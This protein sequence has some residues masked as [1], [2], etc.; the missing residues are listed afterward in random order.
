MKKLVLVFWL[1]LAAAVGYPQKIDSELLEKANAGNVDAQLE[2]GTIY[3]KNGKFK[4][5][6]NW[7][8]KAAE[9]GNFFAMTFLGQ[10]YATG[11]G[12]QQDSSMAADL[13]LKVAI[14]D[15]TVKAR[16][17]ARLGL[18]AL[19][20]SG[21]YGRKPDGTP[22]VVNGCTWIFI[23][24]QGPEI[25]AEF[26]GADRDLIGDVLMNLYKLSDKYPN[27]LSKE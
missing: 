25:F 9:K 1:V 16:Y 13:L 27:V 5:A 14:Q 6:A 15:G 7:F 8:S 24:G 17:P 19:Y 21:N 12:V 18:G 3:K 2:I 10:A 11:E 4:E 22:D 20:L 26:C 23:S